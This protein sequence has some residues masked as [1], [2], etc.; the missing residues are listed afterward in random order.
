MMPNL[1][2]TNPYNAAIGLAAMA[3]LLWARRGLLPLLRRL[4]IAEQPAS[5]LA[6]LGPVIAI[7]ATTLAVWG[8]GL[9]EHGVRI[10]GTVPKGLPGLAVPPFDAGL[11]ST[12]VTPALMLAVVSYWDPSRPP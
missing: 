8:F 12:L 4:G 5:I 6:K 11:W 7:V 2:Q 3:F 10:V 9:S 1:A